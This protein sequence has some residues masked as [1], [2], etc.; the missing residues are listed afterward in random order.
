MATST[1]RDL[2]LSQVVVV[3]I[4]DCLLHRWYYADRL[5]KLARLHR[6]LNEGEGEETAKGVGMMASALIPAIRNMGRGKKKF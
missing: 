4:L 1:K 2:R 3:D 5:K 6:V